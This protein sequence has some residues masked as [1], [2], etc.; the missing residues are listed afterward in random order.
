MVVVRA[1]FEKMLIRIANREDL[2]KQS[3]RGMRFLS[4][5]FLQET[6]V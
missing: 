4:G 6:S 5:P 3:D 1:G 2:Q